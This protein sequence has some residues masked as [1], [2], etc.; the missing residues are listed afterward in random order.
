MYNARKEKNR[1]LL[2][3]SSMVALRGLKVLGIHA[4]IPSAVVVLGSL[5]V[6]AS[7]L[8][9]VMTWRFARAL[10]IGLPL[11]VANTL[12]S[13]LLVLFQLPV[14]LVFYRKRSQDELKGYPSRLSEVNGSP[15]PQDFAKPFQVDL[16]GQPVDSEIY[17]ESFSEA[18]S[19]GKYVVFGSSIIVRITGNYLNIGATKIPLVKILEAGVHGN[20]ISVLYLN[21]HGVPVTINFLKRGIFSGKDEAYEAF[22]VVLRRALNGLQTTVGKEQLQEHRKVAPADTCLQCGAPGGAPVCFMRVI[23][24][25]YVV[26]HKSVKEVLC[27]KHATY[28]GLE[29]FF[30]TGLLGWCGI[31][32]LAMPLAQIR[33]VRSLIQHST[34]PRLLIYLAV[35][36]SFLPVVALLLLFRKQAGS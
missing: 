32:A 2:T 14:F 5:S 7:V 17:R 27:K 33:N 11:T 19:E 4:E 25:V 30:T 13:P 24:I 1:Y 21:R 3:F 10:G 15:M 18:D 12:L 6:I 35:I 23:S 26:L 36:V 29:Y 22:L 8:V 20:G 16:T 31:G 34:L 9:V 28:M